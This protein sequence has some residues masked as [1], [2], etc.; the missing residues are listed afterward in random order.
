M[1]KSKQSESTSSLVCLENWH[2]TPSNSQNFEFLDGIRGI[3]ILMVVFSHLFYINPNATG[4]VKFVGNA[5]GA[6]ALG[7]TV[8]FTLSGFLISL[9]FWKAKLQN[10]PIILRS[11]FLRRF[12]KI[13]PP[14]ALSVLL[15]L[16]CYV[17]IFG[18]ATGYTQSALTWLSGIAWLFP[19][20]GKFNPVMWSLIVEVHFYLLLPLAFLGLRRTSYSTCIWLLFLCL[21]IIPLIA[22]I[23]YIRHGFE[24]SL[25]PLIRVNFPVKMDA[26]AA[27]VLIAGLSQRGQL[28]ERFALFGPLGMILLA[29]ILGVTGA[30][31]LVPQ[32]GAS[33]TPDAA[34]YGTMFA[35]ACLLCFVSKP[36]S[37]SKW[38][39]S[40]SCLRWLGLVSYEWYL[41][42]QP[43]HLWM[44]HILGSAHGNLPKYLAITV[45]PFFGSLI[46]AAAVYWIFSLPILRRCRS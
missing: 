42:H 46:L 9:P 23:L 6:G 1:T 26:F 45:V 17:W 34:H 25:H 35:S 15:L 16:P 32:I 5:L 3:A 2:V 19:V 33:W 11:Y 30:A 8:F 37:A 44:R 4:L 22:K 43:L 10:R 7:V 14:L 40:F 13:Y 24:F 39:L 28:H 20:S 36:D 31:A 12:W 27:G 38:G 21:L 29:G 18:D 41:F